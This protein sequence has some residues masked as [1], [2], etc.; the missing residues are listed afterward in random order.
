M[1]GRQAGT[2]QRPDVKFEGVGNAVGLGI[3]EFV[4][5]ATGFPGDFRE[6]AKLVVHRIIAGTL[7][8][9]GTIGVIPDREMRSLFTDFPGLA[10]I[11]IRD[12]TE[13]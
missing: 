2:Q 13:E 11:D 6:T 12:T 5:E 1:G 7:D 8:G 10:L 3:D 9:N 4:R